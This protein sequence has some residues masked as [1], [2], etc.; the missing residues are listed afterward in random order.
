MNIPKVKPFL[1]WPGGKFRII[2]KIHAVLPQG[3]RL[4]EPFVG[5]G[6]VFLNIDQKRYLL[7]DLNYDLINLFNIVKEEGRD[8]IIDCQ[9]YFKPKYNNSKTYYRLRKKFNS[10]DYNEE[11]AALF[12]YLNRHGFNGLCR[13]NQCRGEFNVP[14]GRYVKPY[15]PE[16]QMLYFHERSQR[17]KFICEDFRKTLKRARKGDVVYCDPPYVPLSKTAN[18]TSYGTNSFSLDDQVELAKMAEQLAKKGIHVVLS[19]HFTK[20][21]NDLYK[22]ARLVKFDVRR[23]ISCK[24]NSR[25]KIPEVL[26]IFS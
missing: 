19:N 17:A 26:A 23:F 14:F 11:R 16:Q 25:A 6:A 24:G 2:D 21:V 15:F 7:N 22:N 18:F 5:S 9:T 10:S 3:N 13:Y 12:L 4:I 1:K 20:F 8:F